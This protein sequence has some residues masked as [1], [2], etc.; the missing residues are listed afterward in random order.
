MKRITNNSIYLLLFLVLLACGG[1]EVKEE[2]QSDEVPSIAPQSDLKESITGYWIMI[3]QS[4]TRGRKLEKFPVGGTVGIIFNESGDWY[5]VSSR[6]G[7][8]EDTVTI[9]SYAMD[10]ER[11]VMEVKET[12]DPLS[13]KK[14]DGKITMNGRFMQLEGEMSFEGDKLPEYMHSILGRSART[15]EEVFEK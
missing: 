7:K 15:L 6:L 13:Y 9:G 5:S 12:K 10:G 4:F 2:P 8:P 14:L 1:E 11:I 3:S